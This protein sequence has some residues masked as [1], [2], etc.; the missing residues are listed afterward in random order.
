M[1]FQ[2]APQAFG[3]HVLLLLGIALEDSEGVL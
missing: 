2:A 3:V 1:L